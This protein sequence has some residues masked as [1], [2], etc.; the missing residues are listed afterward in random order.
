ML[1]LQVLSEEQ[2]T[3][4]GHGGSRITR[5]CATE[6]VD[7]RLVVRQDLQRQ[8]HRNPALTFAEICREARV[9][10]EEAIGITQEVAGCAWVKE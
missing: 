1:R 9:L 5:C 7:L 2:G 8:V 6:P 4:E 10:E 3:M